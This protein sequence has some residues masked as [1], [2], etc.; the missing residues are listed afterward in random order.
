MKSAR[1]QEIGATPRRLKPG[2]L[3]RLAAAVF[4]W[5]A[6]AASASPPEELGATVR[7][8]TSR[9]CALYSLAPAEC[10]KPVEI[11]VVNSASEAPDYWSLPSYAAGAAQAE[12]GRVIIITNRTGSYPYGDEVQTL[13]HELSHVL[14]YRSLGYAPPRWLD[15]GLA[16]RASGE[17]GFSDD[18]YSTLALP[19][20][21][22]GRWSLGKVDR[23]FAGG[24]G[25]VRGSYALARGFVRDLFPDDQAVTSFVLAARSAGSVDVAF[26]QRFGITAGAAFSEWAKRLPWWAELLAMFTGPGALWGAVTALFLLAVLAAFRRRLRW[27]RRWEEEEGFQPS[28]GP[29]A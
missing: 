6:I 20:V 1:R 22:A 23:D 4:I 2:P 9:L 12:A 17:W 27:R 15:E 18:W 11:T 3:A 21:A 7:E 8:A 28:A 5:A 24:E 26:R 19:R 29:D 13:R 10:Q 25:A 16:M 14:L